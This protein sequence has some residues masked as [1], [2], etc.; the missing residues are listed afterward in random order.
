MDGRSQLMN[1]AKSLRQTA[2]KERI[3]MK[4]VQNKLD[5]MKL[6]VQAAHNKGMNAATSQNVVNQ[7]DH[8]VKDMQKDIDNYE[9]QA[10]D[11][12]KQAKS[13]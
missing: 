2:D 1:S 13:I 12:D 5:K 8:Q 4:N 3:V 6:D 11:I 7:L 9:R 10:R